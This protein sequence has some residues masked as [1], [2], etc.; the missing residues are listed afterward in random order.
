MRTA[1]DQTISKIDGVE[2]VIAEGKQQSKID[3]P[4]DLRQAVWRTRR[5]VWA[6]IEKWG[7]YIE[8][9]STWGDLVIREARKAEY[10]LAQYGGETSSTNEGLAG[11]VLRTLVILEGLDHAR[12]RI[13]PEV[14]GWSLAVGDRSSPAVRT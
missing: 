5:A 10:V 1:L 3:H 7:G 2:D 13:G 8:S 14:V 6:V 12:T 11:E 9:E 4:S